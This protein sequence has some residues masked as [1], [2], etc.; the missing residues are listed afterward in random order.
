MVFAECPDK[1]K[2]V[3]SQDVPINQLTAG[4]HILWNARF[5][6]AGGSFHK[7]NHPF[8]PKGCCPAGVPD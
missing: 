2:T 1:I 3:C 4:S 7:C 5:G 6:D 8:P